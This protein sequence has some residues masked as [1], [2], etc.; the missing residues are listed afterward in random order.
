MMGCTIFVGLYLCPQFPVM[1]VLYDFLS[2]L[3]AHILYFNILLHLFIYM[4]TYIP[5]SN[6]AYCFVLLQYAILT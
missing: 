1:T 2:F 5:V 3:Q 6:A 4:C